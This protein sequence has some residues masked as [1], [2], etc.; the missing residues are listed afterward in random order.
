MFIHEMPFTL[1]GLV[2]LLALLAFLERPRLRFAALLG[3]G[4]GLMASTRETV[5]ISLF[6]WGIAGFIW[7]LQTHPHLSLKELAHYVW[8]VKAPLLTFAATLCFALIVIHYTDSMRHPPGLLGFFTTFFVYSPVAGHEKPATYFL[9]LL[10]WP[11]E[12]AGLWW[13]EAGV[14]LFAVYAYVRYPPGTCRVACRFLVHGGLLHLLVYSAIA[15]KTPWLISLAWVHICLAAGMG[16]VKLLTRAKGRW[17]LPALALVTA[18]LFWQGVQ[19][20]R[21]AFRYASDA[22]NPYAYVPTSTDVERMAA[23]LENLSQQHPEL[24]TEAVA[25]VG[26]F[27]WPLPW[28]LRS[29]NQVGYW[30]ELPTNAAVQPLLLT[31]PTA[32]QSDPAILEA[33][34]VLFPRGL[35][36]EVPVTVAIRKD[37]WE[38]EINAP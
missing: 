12:R 11:K 9:E 1:F 34:H 17:K 27:Y 30:D 33:S 25:V 4:A 24:N 3:A 31:L 6:A 29:F 36:H 16:V 18:T 38:R 7:L 22:R 37:I 5:L 21:A 35:R 19:S 15:Y 10:L 2:S 32:M 28:Y 20:H 13:T 23:W 8:K 14:L 26:N